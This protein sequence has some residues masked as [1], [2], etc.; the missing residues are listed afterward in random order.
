MI[1]SFVLMLFAALLELAIPYLA[2]VAIDSYLTPSWA[3]IYRT[4][5]DEN[6]FDIISP[7]LLGDGK[8]IFKYGVPGYVLA[9]RKLEEI[10]PEMFKEV[11]N[12]E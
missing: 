7:G 8:G 9:V 3:K 2:K 10:A 5:E 4:A 6:T 12:N 1:L 11:K